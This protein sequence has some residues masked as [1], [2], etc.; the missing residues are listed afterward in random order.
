MLETTKE[1]RDGR[2]EGRGGTDTCQA[3]GNG[4]WLGHLGEEEP[5]G[6][7]ERGGG[8]VIW[9]KRKGTSQ[10]EEIGHRWEGLSGDGERETDRERMGESETDRKVEG[11]GG[12]VGRGRGAKRLLTLHRHRIKR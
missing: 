5:D 8:R 9:V 6:Q 3:V 12:S 11:G 7:K 4:Q 2:S 10:T 1:D